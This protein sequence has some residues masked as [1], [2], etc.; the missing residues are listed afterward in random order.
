MNKIFFT[1]II[2]LLFK[3]NLYS[4]QTGTI[5]GTIVD[6][7]NNS[8]LMSV[9]VSVIGQIDNKIVTGA[10]TEEDGK[11]KIEE[12]PFGSYRLEINYIGYNTL[13]IPD[14]TLNEQKII[15][16]AGIIKLKQ[17][18][19]TTDEIEVKGEKSMIEFHGDKRILNVD[20]NLTLKGGTALDVLKE[21][22]GVTVDIDGNVSVR[23]SEGVKI[24]VD[25][26][27]F[28]LE[29]QS[30]TST[31]EQIS[32]DEIERVE[33]ITN[34]SVK[35]DAEG[36]SGLINI[37]LKKKDDYGY[38]GALSLNAG[39]NDKYAGGLNFNLRKDNFN[40]TGNYNYNKFDFSSS[41]NS[42]RT[43]YFPD[44]DIIISQTGNG[45]RR[46]ESHNLKGG[47]D[48]TLSKYSS[49]GLAIGYRDR[50]GNG[51]E[52][53]YSTESDMSAENTSEYYRNNVSNSSSNNLDLNL[54]FAL[55]FKNNPQHKLTS[56]FSFSNE[57]EE[58]NSFGNDFELIPANP[59]PERIQ[60][61]EN[62]NDKDY[63][64]I[65]DY[66]LPLTGDSK[67]EAGYK[68][69]M[70]RNDEDYSYLSF[71]YNTNQYELNA[72]LSNRFIYDQN[73]QSFYSA[74]TGNHE[75][76]G[77][78][79]GGRLELTNSDGNLVTT[80][81]NFKRNYFNFFPSVSISRKLG[82]SQEIQASFSSRI[83]RPRP[84]NLNPFLIVI[85][86]YNLEIGNPNLNPEF[87]NSFEL[88]YINY[89]GIGTFT[90]SIFFR[91]TTDEITRMTYL[92][93]SVTTLNT[94]ENLNSSSSYGAEFL[95]SSQPVDAVGINGN[96]SYYKTDVT[97]NNYGKEVTNSAYSW[98]SRLST[99]VNLP[100]EFGF[101]VS[102]AY[103][104]K[105][106]TSQGVFQPIQM[107]DA[108]VKKDFFDNNL[109]I[110]LRVSDIL[111]ASKF[112]YNVT[113]PD[114][115]LT[116]ERTRD[117]RSVFLNLSYKFGSDTKQKKGDRKKV[118]DENNKDN[119]NDNDFDY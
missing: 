100:L 89:T 73:V 86:R 37:I 21:M 51:N 76:F 42:L 29:G 25:N 58:D 55:T 102:Y 66:V 84:Q 96:I 33:L 107:L 28:G 46:R 47:I 114:F 106:V 5:E 67:L 17:G 10:N 97:E 81:E 80:G 22:P 112:K 68:G 57:P 110:T 101:Q 13:V 14:I 50:T 32:A 113:D 23:G 53:I 19:T 119:E 63:Q 59:T 75:N 30:R 83:R 87:T 31:L 36:S 88:N 99:N 85:D 11:F 82:I 105:R 52:M 16:N 77:I 116:S 64:L 115:S 91:R 1:L 109:T 41:R 54:I 12:I 45:L 48:Y 43:N 62:D 60:E 44:G 117:A 92:I 108:A 71:D 104:G 26:K 95:I 39:T 2:I 27:S 79:V 18:N 65:A 15:S 74:Y 24:T 7:T 20:Q 94:F 70:K 103:S 6:F 93:D 4:Q 61:I 78:L 69:S 38:N 34:P 40:I 72:L 9:S 56:E 8:P 111:N 98:S 118:K 49:L 3:L 35:Y 90:P